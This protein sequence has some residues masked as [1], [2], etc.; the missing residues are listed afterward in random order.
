MPIPGPV[1]PAPPAG[2]PALLPGFLPRFRDSAATRRFIEAERQ[3]YGALIREAGIQ[4]DG[5]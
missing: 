1:R 3:R 2:R 4:A 5:G